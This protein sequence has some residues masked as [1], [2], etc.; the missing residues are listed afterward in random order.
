MPTLSS[1]NRS[2]LS[3]KLEG[4]YPS[5][6]GVPQAGDGAKLNMVSETLDYTVKTESSKTIRSDRLVPDIVQVGASA[7]GGFAFEA[8]FREYDPFIT[9]VLGSAGYTHYGTDGVSADLPAL[10]FASGTI[11]A[12]TATSG[13]DSFATLPKGAWF[14]LIPE[15]AASASVK[16]YFAA[17]AF[18]VSATTAPTTTVI[19]L[20]A[21]TPIDTAKAGASML[22]GALVS[23]SWAYNGT[24]LKSY[25]LEVGHLDISRFRQYT[26]M[27]PS[28]MDLKL[29]VGAIV[30]GSFEFMGKG[31]SLLSATGNGATPAESQVFT[32]ANATRGVFDIFEGG[33]SISASTY[34]KSGDISI[35]GTLRMQ[36]AVGVFGAAG[37]GAGTL[38]MTAKLEV[39]FA[40][41]TIYNKLLTGV[42]TSFTLPLLDVDGN[43]YVY[44]FPR[45]KYTAAKVAVG[46]IDQDNMLQMDMEAILDSDATSPTYGKGV[47]VYRVGRLP[48]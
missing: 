14:V 17:R 24:T 36:D 10:T 33:V 7:A 18:R 32:P 42:A 9:G 44:V 29:S 30:T 25:T 46:G 45:T 23:S 39:Y 4:T 11:T 27:V 21:A 40:D 8:Q 37:I 38:K 28:K 1:A 34:I 35:D 31:F 16:A 26:G 15:P 2:Q 12:G 3:Y 47:A 6:F 13:A 22:T 41:S 43:G 19:T 5:Q 20:D 48:V